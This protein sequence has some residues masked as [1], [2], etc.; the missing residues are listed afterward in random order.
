MTLLC[1]AA[2]DDDLAKAIHDLANTL[3]VISAAVGY[4]ER[5][6]ALEGE[7][8]EALIDMATCVDRFPALLR[9]LRMR[10]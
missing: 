4:L 9:R 6:G 3:G 8:H 5:H 10:A 2:V 7:C 1:F